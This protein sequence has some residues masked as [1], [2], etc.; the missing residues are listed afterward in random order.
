MAIFSHIST[1]KLEPQSAEKISQGE[2]PSWLRWSDEEY[3]IPDSTEEY[4]VVVAASLAQYF[5]RLDRA[6]GLLA[7]GQ[8]HEVIQP[9]RGERQSNRI[10]ETLAVIRAGGQV[11]IED[12]LDAESQVFPRGTTVI[13]ITPSNREEF[14]TGVRTLARRGLRIVTVLID[15]AS[16]GGRHSSQALLEML[17]ASSI[18]SYHVH[19]KDDLT[20]VLSTGKSRNRYL[21]S[22]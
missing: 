22:F 13:I 21:K 15:A 20:E 8:S 18:V 1:D 11:S 9:D 19:C 16:F 12:V 3:K 17:R 4:T 14:A 6:V 5:L 7:Y 10:L 2:L